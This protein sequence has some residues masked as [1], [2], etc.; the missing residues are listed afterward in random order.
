[1]QELIEIPIVLDTCAQCYKWEVKTEKNRAEQRERERE[2][3]S[4]AKEFKIPSVGAWTESMEEEQ[5]AQQSATRAT[6]WDPVF[7]VLAKFY[8]HLD[9]SNLLS[10]SLSLPLS[11]SLCL[12]LKH[13]LSLILCLNLSIYLS[14]SL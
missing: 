11:L 3:E 14:F 6:L 13:S 8:A 9:T 5:T 4:K 1:M 2:R 12:S 7:F 10:L